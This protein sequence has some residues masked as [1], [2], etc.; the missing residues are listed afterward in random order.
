MMKDALTLTTN[1]KMP[2]L[3]KSDE[4]KTNELES[5]K[6]ELQELKEQFHEYEIQAE[7]AIKVKSEFLANMSHEIR[8]PMN[9]IIGM[10]H[11]L[12]DTPLTPE[13]K[14]YTSLVFSSANALLSLINDILDFSKIEAG[15]LEFEKRNFDLQITMEDIN[16]MP[17]IQAK[18]K[19]LEFSFIMPP[20]VPRLLK[21]DPGR[22]RQIMNNLTGNAIKF[23]ESGGVTIKISLEDETDTHARIKFSIDDT[24]IGISQDK[25]ANLFQPFHQA[26]AST[27][28]QFGGTGLGL[29]ICKMLVEL[30]NGKI[31]VESDELIGSTFWFIIELEKQQ[32]YDISDIDFNV[33]LTNM[34]SQPLMAHHILVVGDDLTACQ[35]IQGLLNLLNIKNDAADSVEVAIEKLING[36]KSIDFDND[37][38]EKSFKIEETQDFNNKLETFD[39]VIVDI[40]S[41]S[42]N[43]E[44]LIKKVKEIALLKDIKLV[45]ITGTGKKGDANYFERLG[46][47]AYI[48]KPVDIELLS[49]CLKSVSVTCQTLNS[50]SDGITTHSIITRHSI[51]ETKKH[52]K[53]ILVVEDNETNMIVAKTLLSKLGYHADE[54]FNGKE[55]VDKVRSTHYD[56]IFMDC[57]MP[58]MDGF[59]A[60]K[61]IREFERTEQL[62]NSSLSQEDEELNSLN[63]VEGVASHI[64]IVAMT[65]NAMK[66]DREKCIEAGMDDF[67]SKPVDPENLAQILKIFFSITPCNQNLFNTNSIIHNST[68]STQKDIL[69]G[70][71][72]KKEYL[73]DSPKPSEHDELIDSPK[74]SEKDALI[75]SPKS[76][77]NDAL[78]DNSNS[79]D[80]ENLIDNL[81]PFDKIAMVERFGG[82]EESVDLILESFVEEAAEIVNSLEQALKVGEL[83]TIR[84]LS[85]ALKGSSANVHAIPLKNVAF[86]MERASKNGSLSQS[87]SISIMDKIKK[88]FK[89]FVEFA[90]YHLP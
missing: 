67:I 40:Q 11:I 30:M 15:K 35:H 76:S 9:G 77:E 43:P 20:D 5:L 73:V 62:K 58:V 32:S 88:E 87:D 61:M 8:T 85:H 79:F 56:I 89:I 64:P 45:L 60:T 59:T 25:I 69:K 23:T 1:N 51:A 44:T 34:I 65:A 83:E 6:K 72:E 86:E 71:L 41:G 49:D 84:A 27:T 55:G 68:I 38:N 39:V 70:V 81:K 16:A 24:G 22:L 52:H 19:G 10:M 17:A 74:S 47:S 28:R 80:K 66:G 78:I 29:S 18:N 53:K 12:M 50:R 13:Q 14:K 21:G 4:N 82:D 31:G 37:D 48:S 57:Q 33:D 90:G 63:R 75:D 46:F 7:R 26:D 3:P 54:A 42:I 36:V 2:T